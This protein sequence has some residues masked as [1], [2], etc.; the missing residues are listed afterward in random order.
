[1]VKKIAHCNGDRKQ[2]ILEHLQGT[3]E[4]AKKFSVNY[5]VEHVEAYAY[6]MGMAHDI[7]KYSELFQK[8]IQNNLE[9]Q[10]DHSTAGAVEMIKN[11]MAAAAFCI[12]GHHAGIPNGKDATESCLIGRTRDIG[13]IEDYSD[14][15][16]ELVLMRIKE[17]DMSGF[18]QAFFIRMLYS[19]L[20]DADFLDTE[21]F[22]NEDGAERGGYDS[23][24]ILYER[25]SGYIEPWLKI[26][27][28]MREINTIRTSILKQCIEKGKSERGLFS[29]TVPTG[30]GKTVSSLAFA[31]EHAMKNGM[32]RVIYVIPYTSIIEQNAGVF[33]KIL[34]DKNVVEHHANVLDNERDKETGLTEL[35]KLSAE[36]WDAPVIV[37]TNVQFFESLFSNRVSKCRKLHN[38]ANSIIIFDEAQM[39]PFNY[40]KPCVKAIE[41]LICNYNATAVLCTATQ[42]ALDK[43]FEKSRIIEICKDFKSNYIKLKRTEIKDI[44]RLSKKGLKKEICKNNQILIIV[45]K[46]KCAQEI[47]KSL[48][49]EGAYHLSTY[50]TPEHRK[51]V[52]EEI[53]KKLGEGKTVR[54][55]S[56]SLIEAGVDIDFPVVMREKAGIDSIVQ[57]AGRCNRE[58]K[59]TLNESKVWVFELTEEYHPLIEKNIAMTRETMDK[60]GVYDSLEAIQYY[61]S[62]LQ[63]L[64]E[65]SL[66]QYKIIQAFETGLEGIKMPFK[67]VNEIF[68]LIDESTKMLIIP[69]EKEAENLTSEL[70][71]HIKEGYNFRMLLRRLGKYAINLYDYEYRKMLDAGYAYEI[72]DGI[73]VLQNLI[74]YQ[75]QM[76]LCIEDTILI[77]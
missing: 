73:A 56:T 19:A 18:S 64:D 8:K 4:L 14:Y 47:Y 23:V 7:G 20:V 16:K 11:K 6:T 55:V 38:I 58:G 37:T 60:F 74:M 65:D 24:S 70:E 34:G 72:I 39:I 9:I 54:L 63:N 49:A 33:R 61:F 50:M 2:T 35:H 17:P 41:E 66:D 42:P 76:G 36:N 25:L 28:N 31:L 69:N 46:K 67:R 48:P 27:N 22:M 29:L 32:D 44:G 59:R 57:A 77:L 26:E 15:E 43:W 3:A 62:A 45:N 51:R 71:E 12:A 52:I 40:M 30:G 5:K 21:R 13:H 75:E 1:M 10:V 53:K 68:H